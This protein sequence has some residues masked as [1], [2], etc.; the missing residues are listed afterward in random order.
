MQRLQIH[1]A[2]ALIRGAGAKGALIGHIDI[3]GAIHR[4]AIGGVEAAADRALVIAA[5]R[6][7][8]LVH[9]AGEIA[10]VAVIGDI[11]VSIAVHRH[12]P[13]IH[14]GVQREL[15]SR[16]KAHLRPHARALDVASGNR[17]PIAIPEHGRAVAG[18]GELW[19]ERH[20]DRAGLPGGI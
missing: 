8:L 1:A 16:Q 4:H 17:V 5:A 15:R 9:P 14:K 11:E 12:A 18:S 13:G 19:R 20:I 3:S 10:E 7:R 6:E 2:R